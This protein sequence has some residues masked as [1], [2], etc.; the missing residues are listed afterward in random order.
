M[1]LGF[2]VK[3]LVTLYSYRSLGFT[4]EIPSHIIGAWVL[5]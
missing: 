2:T 4:V 3:R 1:N 5:L